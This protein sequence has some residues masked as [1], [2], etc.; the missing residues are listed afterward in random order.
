ME[1]NV[2]FTL[3]EVTLPENSPWVGKTVAQYGKKQAGLIIQ[4]R[5]GEDS[6]MPRG[7]TV[8]ATGDTLIIH[9]DNM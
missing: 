7:D 8:L 5:R 4:I 9:L 1:D 3:R 2:L 6:L